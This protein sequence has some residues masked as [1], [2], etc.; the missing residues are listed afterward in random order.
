MSRFYTSKQP[1]S[2]HPLARHSAW[3]LLSYCHARA[4][5]YPAISADEFCRR[6]LPLAALGARLT[7]EPVIL[8]LVTPHSRSMP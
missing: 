4:A 1:R 2:Q 6:N 5:G 7:T 3:L 8:S